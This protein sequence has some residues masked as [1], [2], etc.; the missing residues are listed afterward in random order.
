MSDYAIP[1]SPFKTAEAL[2]EAM[3]GLTG[4]TWNYRGSEHVGGRGQCPRIFGG[5]NT[6][7]I[8][9][10]ASGGW[11]PEHLIGHNW[12]TD[13]DLLDKLISVSLDAIVPEAIDSILLAMYDADLE[14]C[15]ARRADAEMAQDLRHPTW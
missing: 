7:Y 13:L 8:W 15:M 12:L 14:A 3:T 10:D 1:Q 4:F 11:L 6:I 2:A 5:G 9:Q